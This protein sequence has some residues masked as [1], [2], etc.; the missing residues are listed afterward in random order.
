L[1]E[2]FVQTVAAGIDDIPNHQMEVSGGDQKFS[3]QHQTVN[4]TL[5]GKVKHRHRKL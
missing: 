3:V 1:N 2:R 5:R 4:V